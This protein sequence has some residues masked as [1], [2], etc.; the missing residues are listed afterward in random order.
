MSRDPVELD[1]SRHDKGD[2]PE[3]RCPYCGGRK[4]EKVGD[5]LWC[6]ECGSAWEPK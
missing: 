3:P 2:E 5:K 1:E 4:T 6:S